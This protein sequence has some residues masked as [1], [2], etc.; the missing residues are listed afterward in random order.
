MGDQPAISF[1]CLRSF[2]IV[3]TS[4]KQAGKTGYTFIGKRNGGTYQL[5][6]E[7]S[8]DTAVCKPDCHSVERGVEKEKRGAAAPC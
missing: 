2:S 3:S 1:F 7:E 6:R 8:I 4:I 5:D